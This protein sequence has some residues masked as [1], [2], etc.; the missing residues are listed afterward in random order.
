MRTMKNE[1]RTKSELISEYKS[2]MKKRR[3]LKK[4]F[5]EMA[6]FKEGDDIVFEDVYEVQKK[7]NV[8]S[9]MLTEDVWGNPQYRYGVQLYKKNGKL[10]MRTD[11]HFVDIID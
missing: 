7:G 8:F 1:K 9:V 11:C 10:G 6:E 5:M 2:V 4:A 3:A